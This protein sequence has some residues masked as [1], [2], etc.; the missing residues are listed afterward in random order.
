MSKILITGASG[1]VGSF[2]VEEALKRGHQVYAGIRSTSSKKYLK[3]PKIQFLQLNF[4]KPDSYTH[5]LKEIGFEYVIHNAGLTKAN[6][7]SDLFKVNAHFTQSFA[8]NCSQYLPALKKFLF[9]SSI[10]AYGPAD[11]NNFNPVS[12]DSIPCPITD[13]GRS[14]LEAEG[15]LKKIDSFPWGIIRPTAVF[16]PR[17][18]DMYALFKAVKMGISPK[19]GFSDQKFSFIY[20]KDL[21][22]LMLDACLSTHAHFEAFASDTRLYS[23]QDLTKNI[24]NA[25]HKKVLKLTIPVALLRSMAFLN[26]SYGKI[27]GS[28]PAFNFEKVNELAS[29]SWACDSTVIQKDFNFAPAYSLAEAID[30]TVAWYKAENWL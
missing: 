23:S 6:N 10:A 29:Q 15:L 13:Y 30:E 24:A 11:N 27:I 17:E 4:D 21:A 16:G 5:K 28:Y 12:S 19:I 8:E 3:N 25:L 1:F 9:V 7:P 2:L 26:E 18:K 20:V 14:K 22:R